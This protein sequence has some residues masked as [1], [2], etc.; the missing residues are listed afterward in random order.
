MNL[1]TSF[2]KTLIEVDKELKLVTFN[3]K[4]VATEVAID[5]L[6]EE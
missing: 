5:A 3:E 6:G 1:N 2:S 4:H